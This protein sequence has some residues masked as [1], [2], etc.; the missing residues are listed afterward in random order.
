MLLPADARNLLRERVVLAIVNDT[1]FVVVT[2][3]ET[4]QRLNFEDALR[5]FRIW[6]PPRAMPA[7]GS[8][9]DRRD[10]IASI[11][12]TSGATAAGHGHGA[13]ADG[14]G[15]SHGAK[16]E[17]HGHGAKAEGEGHCASTALHSRR[18]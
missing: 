1:N 12:E 17:G 2:M 9:T 16:A 11:A 8:A 18:L 15:H 7:A 4:V 13:T 6:A 5:A 14:E 3:L 10:S